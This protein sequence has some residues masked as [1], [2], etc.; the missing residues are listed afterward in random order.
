LFVGERGHEKPTHKKKGYVEKRKETTGK[1]EKGNE[2]SSKK[3]L[4]HVDQRALA[5][6]MGDD[7]DRWR[8]A[9]QRAC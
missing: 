4:I 3:T 5:G 8:Q 9:L 2:K 6:K 7:D 1:D